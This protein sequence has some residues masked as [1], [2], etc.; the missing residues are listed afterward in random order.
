[1]ETIVNYFQSESVKSVVLGEK[2]SESMTVVLVFFLLLQQTAQINQLI[3]KKDWFSLI[4]LEI[5]FMTDRPCCFG[6]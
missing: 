2:K 3:K 6:L 4:I 1:M 5:Q